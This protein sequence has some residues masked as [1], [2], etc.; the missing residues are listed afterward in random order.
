M[1]DFTIPL[2]VPDNKVAE[3]VAALRWHWPAPEGTEFTNA[4]LR[5]KLKASVE[6]SIRDIFTRHKEYLRAQ[7]EIDNTLDLT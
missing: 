4:Q 6:S 2:T 7:T 5:A 1:A 3:L